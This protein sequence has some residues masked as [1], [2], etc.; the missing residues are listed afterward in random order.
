LVK[1]VIDYIRSKISQSLKGRIQP[2]TENKSC[3]RAHKKQKQKKVYCY[4]M[5]KKGS[6]AAATPLSLR[7]LNG[8]V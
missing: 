7:Y 6:E 5:V 1:K 4:M 8:Y 2:E 3:I